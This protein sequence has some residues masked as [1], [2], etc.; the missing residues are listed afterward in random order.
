[1]GGWWVG[2]W[3]VGGWW[4]SYFNVIGGI[5]LIEWIKLVS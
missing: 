2:G 4:V 3:W 1:M 5:M